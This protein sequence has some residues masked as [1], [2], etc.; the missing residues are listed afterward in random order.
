MACKSR[1]SAMNM[2]TVDIENPFDGFE[3]IYQTIFLAKFHEN[4]TFPGGGGDSI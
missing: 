4:L 2:L 3:A 1:K